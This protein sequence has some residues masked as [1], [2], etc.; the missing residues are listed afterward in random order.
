MTIKTR[1]TK[2][3][4]MINPI[5]NLSGTANFR[6]AK[7]MSEQSDP[8]LEQI[9][10]KKV[11]TLVRPRRAANTCGVLISIDANCFS[12]RISQTKHDNSRF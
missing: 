12:Q 3:L 5:L 10:L 6:A 11:K 9:G 2:T 4:Y 1:A 8:G 7:R